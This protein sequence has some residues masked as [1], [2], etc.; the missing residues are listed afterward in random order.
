MLVIST[1]GATV[2]LAEYAPTSFQSSPVQSVSIPTCSLSLAI[3]EAYGSN[4]LDNG[5]ALF[6]CGLSGATARVVA[7]VAPSGWID[8]TTTYTTNNAAYLPRGATSVLGTGTVYIGDEHAPWV[9]TYGTAITALLSTALWYGAVH[10]APFAAGNTL[11]YTA[12]NVSTVPCPAN[13][14]SLMYSTGPLLPTSATNTPNNAI[15]GTFVTGIGQFV[16]VSETLMYVGSDQTTAGGGLYKL[17]SPTGG[18]TGTWASY[19]WPRNSALNINPTATV[20]GVRGLVGRAEVGTYALYLSTSVTTVNSLYRYDTSFD[21]AATVGAGFTLLATAST[22]TAFYGVFAVPIVP[23]HTPS[24]TASQIPTSSRTPSSSTT[25]S[26][27][28]T[29]TGSLTTTPPPT[30]SITATLSFGSSPTSTITPSPSNTASG[31][32]TATLTSSP[33]STPSSSNTATNTPSTSG[34][35]THTPSQTSSPTNTPSN[36]PSPS[37]YH[38]PAAPASANILVA[39]TTGGAIT[40]SEYLTTVARQTA[41]VQSVVVAPC[42][43]NLSPDQGF[44]TSSA[45]GAYALFPCGTSS[46]AA[47][48]IARVAPNGYVDTTCVGRR[49]CARP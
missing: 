7:R 26:S 34:T 20:V 27:S 33:S 22:G 41:A 47:R 25:A 14:G 9:G 44:A 1:A 42:L 36:T 16:V 10:V 21:S 45:D 24:R 37:T 8:T 28:A 4:T 23:S 35:P 5:Y 39:S 48:V 32:S 3:Q 29:T 38:L 6:P 19:S 11:I 43:L 12:C 40:I 18:V 46:N 17:T 49:G 2:T 13:S 30:S 31:T 15:A